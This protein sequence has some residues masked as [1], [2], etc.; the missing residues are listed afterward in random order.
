MTEDIAAIRRGLL[1]DSK[2]LDDEQRQRAKEF[3]EQVRK[4]FRK[5]RRPR[6][7]VSLEWL[8]WRLHSWK[9][10]TALPAR[11]MP[12]LFFGP[13]YRTAPGYIPLE[14]CLVFTPLTALVWGKQQ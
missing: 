7:Y 13:D 3:E 6:D 5:G 11:L 12:Q 4:A 9:Y 10:S 2:S 1:L 8:L 14:Q